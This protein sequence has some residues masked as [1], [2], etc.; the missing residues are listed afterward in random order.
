MRH[1]LSLALAGVM[2]VTVA[3]GVLAADPPKRETPVA[4]K[5]V[6]YKA[7]ENTPIITVEFSNRTAKKI[8]RIQGGIR[9]KDAAGKT[10][11][12]IGY[13]A[14]LP[15]GLDAGGSFPHELM[16]WMPRP[17]TVDL[18]KNSP[19]K[20]HLTFEAAAIKYADGSEDKF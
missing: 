5:L 11:D 6:A 14:D 10:L 15:A 16:W 9:F 4:V 3:G 19:E 7:T 2:M 1:G 20:V 12:A 13:T 8:V 17:A 18:L